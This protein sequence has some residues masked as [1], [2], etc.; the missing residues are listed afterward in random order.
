MRVEADVSEYITGGV[1][2]IKCED[3]KWRPVAFISKSLNETE[4][5]YEIHD[6]EML[7]IIRCLDKWRHLL[8]GA[9]NKF[10][11]WSDHKNLEYF[12]SSQKLNCKQ[13]RWVL[14]LS[15]FNFMLKHVLGS[16]MGKANS[17]SRWPDWQKG[18]ERDN[19]NR[20]L[21]KREWLKIRAMQVVEVII[22][23]IDLLEKIRGLEARDNEVIKAVEK[24]KKAGVKMLRD[25]EWR[26]ENRLMLRDRKVYVPKDEKLR[27]E[28][29]WL[30]HDMP[31][32]EHREQWKTI[33]L[34]T[35][36]FWWLG[37]T[38][39]VKKYI[40]G[41]NVYQ[42]NKNQTEIPARKLIPNTV[43]EKPWTHISAD[44]ITKLLLVQGYNSI[45]VVYNRIMKMVHFMPITEKTSAEGVVRLF[46]DNILKL[47]EL[48]KA[49]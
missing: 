20:T 44:F 9:Q 29:I 32:G 28:V 5:N 35:R 46:W 7:A 21:L 33:E 42:R 40:E 36:N 19:K 10:K 13:A 22:E 27:A 23:R 41:C 14:Y 34:V 49:S 38:K 48:P 2:S 16:S 24:I 37:V 4:W 11:I 18:V 39:E 17:L 3:E 47:H 12:M 25:K 30:H 15:R 26:E 45:L 6:R 1:L 31:V 43:L 8:E